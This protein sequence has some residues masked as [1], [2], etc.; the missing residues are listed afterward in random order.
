MCS[1][2]AI[3]ISSE[4]EP[5]RYSS[6]SS[7]QWIKNCWIIVAARNPSNVT[8]DARVGHFIATVDGIR[9]KVWALR[10]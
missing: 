6:R 5:N 2:L 10:Q 1:E 9:R 8:V 7:V 3:L 4:G